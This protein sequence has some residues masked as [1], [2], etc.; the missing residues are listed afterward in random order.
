MP[1]R[2]QKSIRNIAVG[3]TSQ[4]V[5]ILL[6]F[7]TRTALIVGLGEYY[8][9]I[10][11]V[12]A[13]LLGV[14][15]LADLGLGSA[16]TFSLYKPLAEGSKS[17]AE[18]YMVLFKKVYRLIGCTIILIALLASPFL[19]ILING[20]VT[21]Q[22]YIIYFLFIANTALSY[23][24]LN[25]RTILFTASQEKYLESFSDMLFVVVSSIGQIISYSVFNNYILGLMLLVISQ[26]LR[27]V[28]IA[29]ISKK[30]YPYFNFRSNEKL[31]KGSYRALIKNVYA[32][33]IG[34]V[35]EVAN[36][37][38]PTLVISTF[39]SLAASGL[40]SN[41]AIISSSIMSLLSQAFGSITAS[42]GNFNVSA[43]SNEKEVIYKHLNFL[44]FVCYGICSICCL[45]G[46]NPFISAWIG[47]EYLL[48]EWCVIG[49]AANIMIVGAVRSTLIFKD[50]CGIFFQGR[51]RPAVGCILT[52]ALSLFFVKPFGVAGVLWSPVL[53]RILTALWYDPYLVHK[54]VLKTSP[55]GFYIRTLRY[56]LTIILLGAIA[57][58]VI[59]FLPGTSW[60]LFL[61]CV[62]V[63][64]FVSVAGIIILYVRDES[65]KYYLSL[66]KTLIRK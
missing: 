10:N 19:P 4:I 28:F 15:S 38:V 16:I 1:T 51:F 49:I 59:L 26:L 24:F 52:V 14:F 54:Y 47:N 22:V 42:V 8:L 66:I 36:N 30:H 2:T 5:S 12:M 48:N 65:F 13:S 9:G 57:R 27:S 45:V 46:L 3:T 34:K 55:K 63:G 33:A 32:M 50:G 25:Y 56:L 41:Y 29:V 61:E 40:Y 6:Q 11:S 31:T 43:R 23:L 37:N 18:A 21:F 60:L 35:S 17:E 64:F 53:T 62:A 58:G 20:E 7:A 44:S 39:V